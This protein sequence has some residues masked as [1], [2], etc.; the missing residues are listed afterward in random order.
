MQVHFTAKGNF[1]QLQTALRQV[2]R[3]TA[4]AFGPGMKRGINQNVVDPFNDVV[5]KGSKA[6][7]TLRETGFAIRNV[8]AIAKRHNAMMRAHG[9]VLHNIGGN[10]RVAVTGMGALSKGMAPL[11]LQFRMVNNFLHQ[12]GASMVKWGKNMQWAGRQITVGLTV[13]LA[14]L[15]RQAVKVAEDFD[16]EMTRVIK[17]T[18]LVSDRMMRDPN[19]VFSEGVLS[20]QANKEMDVIRDRVWRLADEMAAGFGVMA[21]Q[22]GSAMGELAQMGFRGAGLEEITR[23]S[24]RLAQVSGTEIPDAIQLSRVMVQGFG[25]AIDDLNE[26]YARMNIIEN[27]TALSIQEMA[28]ALPI[29]ASVSRAL[30]MTAQETAGLIAIQKEMGISGNEAATALRTGLL[31]VVMEATDPAIEAFDKLG[32][33]LEGMQA[34]H[35]GDTLGFLEELSER[36]AGV[37]EGTAEMDAF[38]AALGKLMGTRQ[39]ARF[40]ALLSQLHNSAEEGSVAWRAMRGEIESTENV[41]AV[42]NAEQERW[43]N[44]AAGVAQRLRAQINVELAKIGEPLL[45]VTNKFRGFVVGILKWFNNLNDSTKK[46]TI[47]VLGFVAAIG[48]VGML[49]G[50]MTN[51]FGQLLMLFTQF[52]PKQAA[53]TLQT[54]AQKI[55]LDATAVATAQNTEAMIALAAATDRATAAQSRQSAASA[56][57]AGAN[58]GAA[59]AAGAGAAAA[60][61]GGAATTTIAASAGAAAG[62]GM[63]AMKNQLGGMAA[64]ISM[65]IAIMGK[66]KA[67][68][69][70]VQTVGLAALRGLLGVLRFA[71]GPIAGLAKGIFGLGVA[72]FKAGTVGAAGM[73]ILGAAVKL[74]VAGTGIGALVMIVASLILAF[75]NWKSIM[76]GIMGPIQRPVQSL[77]RSF[78]DLWYTI[79]NVFKGA[80]GNSKE[81]R[82]AFQS[83]GRVVGQVIA[84]FARWFEGVVKTVG[85]MVVGAFRTIASAIKFVGALLEGDFTA[86]WEYFKEFA[87]NAVQTVIDFF[88]SKMAIVAEFIRQNDWVPFGD[89]LVASFDWLYENTR[90]VNNELEQAPRHMDAFNERIE[91]ANDEMEA[92]RSEIELATQVKGDFVRA[93][94]A[95]ERTTWRQARQIK[96]I[97]ELQIAQ[98]KLADAYEQKNREIEAS[99]ERQRIL[100]LQMHQAQSIAQAMYIEQQ[101]RREE[102]NESRA[103]EAIKKAYEQV[104]QINLVGE[105]FDDSA[106][107]ADGLADSIDDVTDA[108]KDAADEAH[109]LQQE[110]LGALRGAMQQ[111]MS[112]IVT[113]VTDVLDAQRDAIT[114]NYDKL[115]ER[116]KAAADREQKRIEKAGQRRVDAIDDEIKKLQDAEKARQEHFRREKVR[117]D[118]LQSRSQGNINIRSSLARGDF[119]AA[120]IERERLYYDEQRYI[121]DLNQTAE[122]SA[123]ER[124]IEELN[125]KRETVQAEA[126]L[127]AERTKTVQEENAKRLKNE[128]E[129]ALAAHAERRRLIERDLENW[130]RV[131]PKTQ[132]EFNK[133]MGKLN[134]ILRK[135]GVSMESVTKQFARN[136]G[137]HLRNGFRTGVERARADLAE[138]KKWTAA[139]KAAG[140][141]ASDGFRGAMSKGLGDLGKDVDKALRIKGGIMNV[142][143]DNTGRQQLKVPANMVGYMHS[144]GPVMGEGGPAPLGYSKLKKDE[145]PRIL[146]HGEYVVQKK[147]V[148]AVGK[149]YLEALNNMKMHSGGFVDYTKQRFSDISQIFSGPAGSVLGQI[150][151]RIVR[152]MI[153]AGG[154]KPHEHGNGPGSETTAKH[155]R[156]AASQMRDVFKEFASHGFG[157][158]IPGSSGSAGGGWPARQWGKLSG[159]TAAAMSFI[160]GKWR[161]PNGVGAGTDRGVASSDHSWGKALDSM[162]SKLGTMPNANQRR[163]G[164]EIANWF[165]KNPRR[166]G[167]KYNIYDKLWKKPHES[168]WKPYTRYGNNPGPT[169]GHYDH[170][171]TSFMHGGGLVKPPGMRVGG[172]VNYDNTIANLHKKETVLTAPLSASLQQG[173][174]NME[175]GNIGGDNINITINAPDTMDVNALADVVVK[176]IDYAKRRKGRDRRV[177]TN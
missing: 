50:I 66:W 40:G 55:A 9:D 42:W 111:V 86:A 70:A 24:L 135:G 124:K 95:T 80:G 171:H 144:G 67:A 75:K 13:P 99:I 150:P 7:L 2:N 29:V 82:D 115:E 136:S 60:G 41:M 26:Q 118:Y 147:A 62:A 25:V 141:A 92:M 114:S 47:G 161:L 78:K 89:Q 104:A 54:A 16:R 168:R 33:S 90:L 139:G 155:G 94:L 176:K 45:A 131:T 96:G 146:Q 106:D 103:R 10:A 31:R 11:G 129:S 34:R 108:T 1:A 123:H 19:S 73:H 134:G 8:G 105:A 162:V 100:M 20:G 145:E 127:E 166:F 148:K 160:R 21:Q 91:S 39:A 153:Q 152:N 5:M 116:A 170:V 120:A 159:N 107:D 98:W 169:L 121:S 32:I 128:R 6:N 17:V 76:A 154:G 143:P 175:A 85:P 38:M 46:I 52:L 132:A 74:L 23:A 109:R 87:L 53:A 119:D 58:R 43:Q 122:A 18:E 163:T 113:A 63:A 3:Q 101:I 125:A 14:L 165:D 117:L 72:I 64:A 57:Q 56:R 15:G 48:P 88:I 149:G 79:Q 27:N 158:G 177:T 71:I 61:G 97:T 59:T 30:G 51:A 142:D 12:G 151:T 22:T 81:L 65:N 49:L 138:Q 140:K 174:K 110:W 35:A 130:K 36:M 157:A 133:H 68:W 77:V 173:I 93:G 4:Q 137:T 172:M 167:T 164:W 37:G 156:G 112:D 44:S 84:M 28:T 126:K 69:M 102:R 83:I